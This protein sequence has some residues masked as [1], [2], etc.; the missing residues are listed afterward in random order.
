[1][2]LGR[3]QRKGRNVCEGGGRL[4]KVGGGRGREVREKGRGPK[5]VDK[6]TM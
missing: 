3:F 5:L 2:T 4:G 6:V 1:M